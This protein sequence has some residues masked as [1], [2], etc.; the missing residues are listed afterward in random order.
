MRRGARWSEHTRKLPP[1][2]IGSWVQL[3]NLRGR[4]PLKSDS[5]GVVIGKHNENSYAV[6]V[7]GSEVVTVRN[8]ITLR[9]I[10][11]PVQLHRPVAIPGEV[12]LPSEAPHV[13]PV[14]GCVTRSR[15]LGDTLAGQNGQPGKLPSTIGGQHGKFPS[16]VSMSADEA[17]GKIM[18][19]VADWDIPGNILYEAF[20]NSPSKSTHSDDPGR[21]KPESPPAPP[22]I[23]P[24]PEVSAGGRGGP[25]QAGRLDRA[26]VLGTDVI[27]QITQDHGLGAG[28]MVPEPA[29]RLRPVQEVGLPLTRQSSRQ[30]S[31]V[32]KFQAGSSGM[33]H[34]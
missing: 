24:S 23:Q 29:L 25:R 33:E 12:R 7:N 28:L 9:R 10:P 4:H 14:K 8:R 31:N 3:Q 22:A 18:R 13:S 15:V 2:E 20:H 19:G 21:R 17:C 5:S 16:R 30:R 1:L 6:K 26:P 32:V 27:T 11:T 34:T